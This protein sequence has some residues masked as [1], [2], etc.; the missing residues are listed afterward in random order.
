M[1]MN[2]NFEKYNTS[3][4]ICTYNEEKRIKDTII[5]LLK[6]DARIG[7]III[8]DDN[9]TDKT[10]E[11]SLGVSDKVRFFVKPKTGK[12]SAKGKNSS[13]Y[14]GGLLAHYENLL[15]L[16]AD[17]TVEKTSTMIDDLE[18]GAD[19]VGGIISIVENGSTLSRLE[20]IEYRIAIKSARPWLYTKLNYLNNVSG[21]FFGIKRENL[22]NNRI[23]DYV[24]GEDFYMTQLGIT[25][26]WNIKLSDS[27]VSTYAT[28]NTK[29]LFIQRCRWVYGFYTVLRATGRKTPLIELVTTYYRTATILAGF[30]LGVNHTLHWL[31]LTLIVLGVYFANELYRVGNVKDTLYMMIYRQINFASSLLF[32]VYGRKWKVIR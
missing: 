10:K 24:C 6:S 4:I 28:P 15:M 19:L 23:P 17:V 14:L 22:I 32:M 27:E 31:M 21:A 16:D 12:N 8:V 30:T 9:S 13:I 18:E 2:I 1:K 29:A 11:I 20:A 7:E 25:K 26:N 3:A 5:S